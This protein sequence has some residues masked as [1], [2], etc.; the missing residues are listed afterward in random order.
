MRPT[1]AV[2]VADSRATQAD[3][4]SASN[5]VTRADADD[6]LPCHAALEQAPTSAEGWCARGTILQDRNE[7]DGAMDAYRTATGLDARLAAAY[8]GLADVS[9]KKARPIDALAYG[10]KA[11]LLSRD[12]P[13]NSVFLII[14]RSHYALGHS[15]QALI[16]LSKAVD[17]DPRDPNAYVALGLVFEDQSRLSDA[18][19]A[20]QKALSLN[21]REV[22]AYNNL[23]GVLIGMKQLDLAVATA[24]LAVSLAPENP[25]V[26]LNLALAL[27]LRGDEE[28][29][30]ATYKK[31]IAIKPDHG[32]ALIELCHYRQHACDWEGLEA[33]RVASHVHSYRKGFVVSPFSVMTSTTSPWDQ[34]AC[35]RVWAEHLSPMSRAPLA[36]YEPRPHGKRGDRLKLGY[37]SSDF[38]HHATAMLIVDLLE[39]HD[40]TKFELFGYSLGVD[41]GSAMRQRLIDA[42]ETF[43][44]F[45]DCSD[46][47]AARL[48]RDDEIDILLDLKGFTQNARLKILASRP[49]PVQVNYLGFPGTM[50]VP[51]ID[52]IIADAT[53]APIAHEAHF[54]EKIV[55]LPHCYQPNDRKRPLPAGRS[56]RAEYNLPSDAFVFCCFNNSYKITPAIFDIWMRLLDSKAGSVLWLLDANRQ[57][58]TNLRRE[59]ELRGIAADRLVFAPFVSAE[60]HLARYALADLFLDTFPVNAHTTASEALWVG[61]P[62]VTCSGETFASRVAGSLL[63]AIGLPETIADSLPAYEVLARDLAHDP[64]RLERLREALEGN[65]LKQPLFDTPRY[66]RN[67]EKALLQM[68]RRRDL[69]QAPEAFSLME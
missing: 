13:Q 57:A 46:T 55:R 34:L 69:A 21:P 17:L 49:A 35:A 1:M 48:I 63:H 62:L 67:F 3:V 61:V 16:A 4:R 37:L 43:R 22:S 50:G 8:A 36:S 7:L 52:Y 25:E 14:G 41:D 32:K 39:Q 23:A 58:A 31:V 19:N 24:R 53:V 30:L 33:Q 42:F 40:K 12:T 6:L 11:A 65:R 60:D 29:A 18:F 66:A 45:R 5:T 68:Q 54:S 10:E 28:E 20:Y 27:R 56:S 51:F 59:A 9:L 44:D 47:D 15:E 64:G 38:H 2:K 26:Y